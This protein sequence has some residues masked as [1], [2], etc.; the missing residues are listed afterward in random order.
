MLAFDR[1]DRTGNGLV[2]PD[3][4]LGAYDATRHPDVAAGRRRGR[5]RQP[6]RRGG[7]AHRARDAARGVD[8]G[9]ARLSPSCGI[10]CG[11]HHDGYGR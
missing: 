9:A 2:E 8:T 1:M 10:I 11:A 7:A 5:R 6:G 4:V 3:D